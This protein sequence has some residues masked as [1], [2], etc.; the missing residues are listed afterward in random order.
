MI[1]IFN[2]YKNLHKSPVSTPTL[3]RDNDWV[4]SHPVLLEIPIEANIYCNDQVIVNGEGQLKGNIYSKSCVISGNVS[5][6]IHCSE[7][8]E[9]K[10]QAVISGNIKTAAIKIEPGSVVNG[11]ISI[12]CKVKLPAF[13]VSREDNLIHTIED[14]KRSQDNT[15]TIFAANSKVVQLSTAEVQLTVPKSKQ[16]ATLFSE[17]SK[18]SGTTEL[19]SVESSGHWW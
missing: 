19:V 13:P 3:N 11:L 8:I 2:K 10:N 7:F 15:N 5:G 18:P 17:P 14:V 16:R 9:L 4:S 6:D 12:D 1:R